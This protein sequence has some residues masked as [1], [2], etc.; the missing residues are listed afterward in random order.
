MIR[1]VVTIRA[2]MGAAALVLTG[3]SVSVAQSRAPFSIVGG[4]EYAHITEDEGF[5]GAGPGAIVGAQWHITE[6]TALEVEV[7]RDRHV[8]D[9]DFHAVATDPLG[10]VHPLPYTE[11]WEGTATFVMGLVSHRFG[12][13]RVPVV[14]W[15]GGGLMTHAGTLRGPLTLPQVPANYTVLSG[16]LQTQRGSSSRAFTSE[17]GVGVDVPIG[18]RLIARPFGGLRLTQAGGVGPKYIIRVGAR[19]AFRL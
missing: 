7:T 2:W 8:R 15:G 12:S 18:S 16:D 9:L 6:Q 17:G 19:L 4:A 11:R 14:A 13:S 10:R 3:A 1:A 5:L